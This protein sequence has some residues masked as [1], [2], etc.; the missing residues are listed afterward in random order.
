MRNKLHTIF[1]KRDKYC[2]IMW[3]FF[4]LLTS[5]L[6]AQRGYY[7][8]P[9]KRYEANLGQLSNG[10]TVTSKSY[11]QGDLQ[12]EATDQQCVNMSAN[13]ATV[14]WTLTEAADGLVVRYSVPDGQTATLGVYNGNTKLTTLTLT[15]TWSWEYL[16]SNGNPNNNGITNQNPRM[17]FDEVRYKLPAK[18]AVSGTL[19]LV[20]ESG[21]VHV[22]FAEMEPIATAVTAPAGSVTYTGNGSD[23]Q[24][25]IDANGG[26]KIFVPSG[27][28]NVNR[29]LYFGVANTSLVGAGMW[30]TQ[31]N[32]TNT[33]SLN[34]GLRA[35]AAGI[36]FTD[37]YLTTNSASRSNSY[38]AIN[39]V[40]TSTSTVKNIWA[41]H[42]ECGAWIAQYN[43]G[44]PAIAD[45]F[46]VSHCRFRNNYA[47]GI[48]L[49]KGTANAIVEH[50]NFRNNGDDDQAIWSADGLEC[51]NNT[52]RYN[53]SENCW[54]A[55]G[56]A[57]YGGKNNKAYN[58]IIKDN[59]EAG[60]RVSNNFPGA[61]FNND[62]MHE[63]HDITVTACGTFNDTY[64][65]PVA[66]VDIFSATNAGSQVKNVQL[67]SID[68]L[69]SRNDAISI[70]KRSGDGI[71]NLSFKDITVNG[72]GKEYPNNNALNRNWGRG[73][74]VLIAGSPA[75]NGT[76]CNMNYSNRG[77]NA[78]ANEEISAIGTFSWT[79]GSNC[80]STSVPVSG[81]TVSP[82]TATLG[83]GATQ[84]LTPTVAPANA[85]NKTVTY[86]SNNTGVATVN[87]SGLV[88]AIASGSATITVTT[89][90][91]NKTATVVITV[92]SSNVAVTSVSLS[93]TTA[94]LSVGGTQQLTPTVLPSNA[95]N[96]A[97]SYASNNTGVATVN[98]SGLVTAVANGSAIITVTT[99][100]G[101]KTSTAT[102]TVNTATGNYFTIK[103]KWTNNYLYDAG[104][105][106]GYGTT[107]AN[108]NYKWE[109][110]AVDATYF[111][112]KNVGTG[113]VM[114]IE[115]LTGAVQCTVAGPDWMSA[116]WSTENVDATWVRIKNRWQTGSMIHIENLNGSAQY[117]GAQNNWD[118]AQWQFQSTS[119]SKKVNGPEVTAE[120][121]FEVSIYPNPSIDKEFNVVLPELN[122]DDVAT[123]TVTDIN[124]RKVLL[125]KLNAS[126]KINHNLGSGIYIVT[127][128]SN[129]YNVSKKLIV[130]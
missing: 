15:S 46:T 75:G 10:S 79:Q 116:Q 121:N 25:F 117:A 62:G 91:G 9:Y 129:S 35:N 97:V 64:N 11:V 1:F 100:D 23:L 51:I 126:A 65:N 30:Y 55:C 4:A 19:K 32:F 72:T 101:N 45:G 128:S 124:G 49:C 22:D 59:L 14:Q 89:Q 120:K 99:A 61:P 96:K 71:Y 109:K 68:I 123:V 130:K 76:Y 36:S 125:N 103:N 63:I 31:I 41:E 57:I 80:S 5:N 82:A 42:F 16:W 105:N 92:S 44:G 102:I 34:G 20:R 74:F 50:C 90:D 7:D 78:T 13:N 104:A 81:V 69:D 48:N 60:I 28:Y 12:S 122:A 40:F 94:T 67:Y 115:N 33:S 108:N 70:S 39:G 106:V 118:S 53:T 95:T 87:G 56:L 43:T 73:Y 2:H 52:F 119:T 98:A 111:I 85:T 18:I 17:R 77:G 8:A 107:V 3:I 66:A 93:P 83:V 21:N 27:V 6:F 26:K 37:L 114:H 38:K 88:T 24:T 112:L 110:V 54:R 113:D 58:L 84:Q 29:E 86:S 127:I 47:D